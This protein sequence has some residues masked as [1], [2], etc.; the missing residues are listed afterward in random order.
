MIFCSVF[1][2]QMA[3]C[4][5]I[6]YLNMLY[7]RLFVILWSTVARKSLTWLIPLHIDQI[8]KSDSVHVCYPDIITCIFSYYVFVKSYWYL[9]QHQ[10]PLTVIDQ[11][12]F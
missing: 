4:Q 11:L 10:E 7:A 2:D 9:L 6:A 5:G 1:Q 3:F 12:Y 8:L